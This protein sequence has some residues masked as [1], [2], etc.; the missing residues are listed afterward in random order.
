MFYKNTNKYFF[1]T[2]IILYFL[3]KFSILF[4]IIF[5]CN[6]S[7]WKLNRKDK[8]FKELLKKNEIIKQEFDNEY[9]WFRA[10][11]N[12]KDAY[13]YL[14]K[15]FN[16]LINYINLLWYYDPIEC[17]ILNNYDKYILNNRKVQ[18]KYIKVYK[19]KKISNIKII[20]TINKKNL[21]YKSKNVNNHLN[22]FNKQL[23]LLHEKQQFKLKNII[24]LIYYNKTFKSNWW[25]W[26]K[27]VQ[28]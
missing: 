12:I 21:I 13:G 15:D 5:L 3:S 27:K 2:S 19:F 18:K 24:L 28:S 14:I 7:R 10:E 26:F 20:D 6:I 9:W 17:L 1:F 25:N 16:A 11:L 4:F 22:N 8:T 23:K